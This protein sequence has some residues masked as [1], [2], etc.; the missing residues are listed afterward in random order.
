MASRRTST[1]SR[2][3]YSA[4]DTGAALKTIELETR[5]AR[6]ELALT[7]L[8]DAVNLLTRRFVALQAHLDHLAA[9][10]GRG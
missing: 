10:V 4:S 6:V 2:T 1:V 5:V 9:R 3:R 7:Q 8:E